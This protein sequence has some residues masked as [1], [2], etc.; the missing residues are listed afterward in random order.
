VSRMVRFLGVVLLVLTVP[1][2]IGT[3]MTGVVYLDGIR[4]AQ[5]TSRTFVV[6]PAP[7]VRV[8]GDVAD[9]TIVAGG[10]G[11][12]VIEQDVH[13]L[14]L[15]RGLAEQ[16]VRSI[17]GD[18]SG[19]DSAVDVRADRF[20]CCASSLG[21]ND[22]NATLFVRVPPEASL[23]VQTGS[24]DVGV[25]GLSGSIDVETGAGD[26]T[27][28]GLTATGSVQVRTEGGAVVV[29][30]A[31]HG[32]R[33]DVQTSSGAIRLGLP[34][35]TNAR[36]SAATQSGS[37]SVDRTWPIAMSTSVATGTLGSGADGSIR[38]QSISGDIRIAA[39]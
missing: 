6:G 2:T 21:V 27:L 25:S 39:R 11:Q 16:A 1:L 17:A 36:L 12:V 4:A 7:V 38:L 28:A 29:S 18:A 33:L 34:S 5:H 14:A 32:G 15:T 37:I 19:T 35:S 3:A 30:G 13:A 22:L 10:P 24:G 20:F 31:L 8:R 23:F 26:V 9:I